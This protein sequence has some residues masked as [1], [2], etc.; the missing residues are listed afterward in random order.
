MKIDPPEHE[1][2]F[3]LLKMLLRSPLSTRSFHKLSAS[4]YETLPR[5]LKEPT[6]VGRTIEDPEIQKERVELTRT[7]TP[8]QLAEMHSLSDIPIPGLWERGRASHRT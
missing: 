1:A 7:K 6:M 8:S 3:I 4:V 2:Q 5:S